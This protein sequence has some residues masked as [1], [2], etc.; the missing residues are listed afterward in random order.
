MGQRQ[1]KRP[2]DKK[3]EGIK[4]I[5]PTNTLFC[6]HNARTIE[7]RLRTPNEAFFHRNTKLLGLGRQF[8]QINFGAFEV[9]SA[10]LSAPILVL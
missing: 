7:H 10:N 8:G 9:F 4:K 5:W 3:Q 6:T 1:Q 2:Q